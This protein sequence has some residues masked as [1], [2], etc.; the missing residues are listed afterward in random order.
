MMRKLLMLAVLG[1]VALGNSSVFAATTR[2]V[3]KTDLTP[4]PPGTSCANAGY[5]TISAA[6]G[7]ATSGDT[8]EVCPGIYPELV[9]VDK[10]LTFLGPQQGVDARTRTVPATSEAVVGAPDGAFQIE[11]DKVVIDGFT[12]Q[13]VVNNPSAPPFTGLGAGIWTNPGFSGTEGGHQIFNNIIQA[14]IV[15]IYLNN[16][17]TLGTLV[18]FNL[19]RDNTVPGASSGNGIYSDVGLCKAVINE[20]KFSGN[21]TGS[22]SVFGPPFTPNTTDDISVTNNELVA[23]SPE[24]ISF[25]G[26]SNST[27]DG[28][29]STGS[30]ND[31]TV[32]LFGNDSKVMVT[33]NRLLNGN[34]AIVVDN[35][36]S[37]Y[38]VGP[39]SDITAHLNCIQGN[40]VA[41]ME[42]DPF[43][44][45]TPSLDAENNWWGSSSGP[46]NPNNPTGTGDR[47]IALQNNVDFTPW[48]PTAPT[49]C[50]QVP[51]TPGKATGGGKIESDPT[52]LDLVLEL[53]T[54]LIKKSFDP[55]IVGSQATFGF[56][57]TCCAPTRNLEYNDHQANVR[58]KAISIETFV[59]S[60][61]SLA[62]PTTSG[63]HA[64]FKGQANETTV[65]GTQQVG[66]TVDVDDCGEPGSSTPGGTDMFKIQT[67]D[68]M[69][70]G[71]LIG[72]NIQI[73]P[74]Q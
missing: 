40:S 17:C 52:S 31:A 2:W 64:Q 51:N 16:T 70:G 18:Q 15:G 63:K 60:A 29:I 62:C 8:I 34:R 25:V 30:T 74:A 54:L 41:G 69:A 22:V 49:G 6:V 53:A 4:T 5:M 23:P 26:V 3:N 14:N 33:N 68:Y 27:I 1:L 20:N 35:P 47:I 37:I 45:S 32:H 46:T 24:S 58:I 73:R 48:L 50:P 19:I 43:A 66:F 72:G 59:I 44:Y 11:A 13:D 7:A 38:G 55:T 21:S 65:T 10:T 71:P 57:V 67:F 28:N 12:I 61:P 36:L 39:N 9:M 56:V 42:V